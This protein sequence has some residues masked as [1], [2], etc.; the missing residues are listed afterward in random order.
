MPCIKKLLNSSDRWHVTVFLVHDGD[1]YIFLD[2]KRAESK[3][4]S[5][6]V[7]NE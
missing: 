7:F 6:L 2:M 4:L 5:Y 1:N 3:E